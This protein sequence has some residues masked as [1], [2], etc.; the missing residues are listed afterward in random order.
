[1]STT[2]PPRRAKVDKVSLSRAFQAASPVLKRL[3]PMPTTGSR[4][5][6]AGTGRVSRGAAA[7]AA[8]AANV[9][10]AASARPALSAC[11][12]ETGLSVAIAAPSARKAQALAQLGGGHDAAEHLRADVDL[13]RPRQAADRHQ[14]AN[15]IAAA[16]LGAAVIVWQ[17]PPGEAA[18]ARAVW[19]LLGPR[20]RGAAAAADPLLEL[21]AGMRKLAVRD[22]EQRLAQLIEGLV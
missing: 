15:A 6:V 18:L 14:D 22:A 13:L 10:V 9:A 8:C 20:L 21:S 17:H 1:M 2:V 4:T 12:R 7:R 11:R 19:R 16:E 5:P 3:V